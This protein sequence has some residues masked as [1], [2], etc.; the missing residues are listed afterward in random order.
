MLLFVQSPLET[1]PV[2][3]VASTGL[4]LYRALIA[5]SQGDVCNFSP[6]CSRYAGDA[7]GEYG[8][9]WGSLMASDRLLRCNPWAYQ[10]FNQHYLEIKDLKFYDPAENN[11]ILDPVIERQPRQSDAPSSEHLS[12]PRQP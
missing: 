5:P 4:T 11:Y 2:K 10:S 8:I 12:P 1:D 7:I 6:S 3:I 9:F